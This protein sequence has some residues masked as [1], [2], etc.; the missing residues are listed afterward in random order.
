MKGENKKMNNKFKRALSS[1]LA[2]IML[3]SCVCVMNVGSVFAAVDASGIDSTTTTVW[4][5][6]GQKETSLYDLPGSG[7]TTDT[8]KYLS[9]GEAVVN[10]TTLE[11]TSTGVKITADESN[12]GAKFNAVTAISNKAHI[13]V[14]VEAGDKLYVYGAPNS[15]SGGTTI[16]LFKGTSYSDDLID[17]KLI[18]SDKYQAATEICFE[19]PSTVSGT[20]YIIASQK[21]SSNKQN[22]NIFAVARVRGNGDPTNKYTI[23]GNLGSEN[24][25]TSG[26]FTLTS[27][28]GATT[29]DA[30]ISDGKYTVTKSVKTTEDAPFGAGDKFT[31]SANNYTATPSEITL[32]SGDND[33]SFTADEI[34]FKSTILK[35]IQLA[36]SL[37]ADDLSTGDITSETS[38][39]GFTIIPTDSGTAVTVSAGSSTANG[40]NITNRILLGGKGSTTKRAI[41]FTTTE[42][43]TT[44]YVWA[45]SANTSTN[46]SLAV[47]DANGTQVG[48][49]ID[50][51][52]KASPIP[53]GKVLL[54]TAGDYYVYSTDSGVN[55]YLIGTDKAVASTSPITKSDS[56]YSKP[57]VYNKDTAYYAIAVIKAEDVANA[58]NTAIKFADE[59][60][61]TVYRAVSIN[62]NEYTAT[63]FGGADNDYVLGVEITGV[64]EVVATAISTIQSNLLVSIESA[65]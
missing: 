24:E 58:A 42:A 20:V 43:N 13:E 22:A 2:F 18:S 53:G 30:V 64:D 26:S 1:I 28:D 63:D 8:L 45:L 17:S 51:L 48:D 65:E 33:Y 57:A 5:F 4:N 12:K 36:S 41:K 25:L 9:S 21:D 62:N 14:G 46:R 11:N 59:T 55:V 54:E 35:D 29:Y 27:A 60:F 3:C 23:T 10:K 40:N 6:L 50:A 19:I 15:S 16:S 31:V 52:S 61:T 7:S 34:S 39:N 56:V 38:K 37:S 32:V 44:V 47:A 49:S